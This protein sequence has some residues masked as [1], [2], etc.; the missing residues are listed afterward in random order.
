[1]ELTFL[2]PAL[3]EI[4]EKQEAMVAALGD[5]GAAA[6]AALLE[7]MRSVDNV[8]GLA[9]IRAA[10]MTAIDA[11]T[12]AIKLRSGHTLLFTSAHPQPAGTKKTKL[13]WKLVSRVKIIGIE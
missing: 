3:R 5:I 4:C 12:K 10:T 2:T 6:V 1:L 11:E 7:D 8:H 13:D 9:E